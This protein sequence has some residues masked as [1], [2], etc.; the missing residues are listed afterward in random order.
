MT[1]MTDMN[2]ESKNEYCEDWETAEFDFGLANQE[3]DEDFNDVINVESVRK[4]VQEEPIH[5]TP[6]RSTINILSKYNNTPTKIENKIQDETAQIEEQKEIAAVKSILGSSS[7]GKTQEV[8]G[9]L[10][11]LN[12][13]FPSLKQASTMKIQMKD[14]DISE[15][16]KEVCKKD[17]RG[18]D[19]K[20]INKVLSKT[21]LCESVQT[22]KTCRHGKYCRFA[23][24]LEELLVCPC[25]FGANC[26]FVTC[27]N[28][29]YG[30]NGDKKCNRLH[31][32]EELGD[33]YIRTGLKKRGPPTEEEKQ[34]ACDEFFLQLEKDKLPKETT[35]TFKKQKFVEF[36]KFENVQNKPKKDVLKEKPRKLVSEPLEVQKIKETNEISNKLRALNLY[37][38]R[39]SETIDRFKK[40]S[41]TPAF[42]RKQIK[43]L[44]LEIASAKEEVATMEERLKNVDS[45]KKIEVV[46]PIVE[47]TKSEP[48]VVKEVKKSIVKEQVSVVLVVPVKKVESTPTP[49]ILKHVLIPIVAKQVKDNKFEELEEV[50]SERNNGFDILKDKTK[51]DTF[52]TKTRMCTFGKDCRRGKNC[53]F[54]HSKEELNV[55]TCAFGNCCKFVN[56]TSRGFE[57]VSKTKICMH[58]HPDEH[59]NNF[60]FRVGIDKVPVR[61]VVQKPLQIQAKPFPAPVSK[62]VMNANAKSWVSIV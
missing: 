44:E 59:I 33:Y 23:H 57:N 32:D 8:R 62:P 13:E 35:K 21:K 31:P 22:G 25:D 27:N 36:K 49:I 34:Q 19:K 12:L 6:N 52:L 37:I 53:R 9:T 46:H 2:Y 40:M 41:N 55:S 1:N 3:I 48:V 10:V 15:G 38:Q 29:V 24:S 60:Y 58:K 28:G 51:M 17:D 56:R 43:K 39:K 5:R 4:Y 30:N 16:W 20:Q 11:E 54:A 45:M 47:E 14:T 42:Y 26:K 50:K 7:W 61:T 18:I